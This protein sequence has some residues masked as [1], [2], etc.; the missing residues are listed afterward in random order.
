MV[1]RPWASALSVNNAD[2]TSANGIS[3]CGVE[4]ELE[5]FADVSDRVQ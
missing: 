1:P 3:V 2:H 4:G 5:M